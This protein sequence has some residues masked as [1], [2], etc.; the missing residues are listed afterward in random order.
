MFHVAQSG[1]ISTSS[2]DLDNFEIV[3]PKTV[4]EAVSYLNNFKTDPVAY[5][6]GIDLVTAFRENKKIGTLVWLKDIGELK[7]ISIIDNYLRIGALV[8]L[9]EGVDEKKLDQ[10]PGFRKALQKIKETRTDSIF[11]LDIYFPH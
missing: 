5:A 6:G 7:T 10:V 2:K 8:S 4:N 3:R 1:L 11:I 9:A